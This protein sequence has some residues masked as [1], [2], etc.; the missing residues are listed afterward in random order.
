M[1]AVK[2][3][4]FNCDFEVL[5]LS[6][7]NNI[8]YFYSVREKYW[9]AN[10][11]V[12][13]LR[14]LLSHS[15]WY[16]NNLK[17]L[18]NDAHFYDFSGGA[19]GN[20]FRSFILIFERCFSEC[21]DFCKSLSNARNSFFFTPGSY[22]KTTESLLDIFDG[23]KPG[24]KY[25]NKILTENRENRNLMADAF[26][27]AEELIQECATIR[28]LGFYG[29]HQGFYYC[30]S[31]RRI[32]Q[33]VGVIVAT[34]SDLYQNTGGPIS[35]AALTILNGIKYIM[36]PELRAQQI[37]DV[38]QNSSVEFLKAFWSLSDIH[39][40]K[41]LP[42]WVCPKMEVKEEIFIPPEPVSLS[43]SDENGS[44]LIQAPSSHFP[45]APVRCLLLSSKRRE[46]QVVNCKKKIRQEKR[47]SC[48]L[49]H[50][51]GGGFIAQNPESHEIY[52]RHWA[53]DL[54]VPIL[55]VDYSLSPGAPFPRALE[56]VLFAYAWTLKNAEKLGWTGETL[57]CAGDSAGGN[58]LMGIILKII[59]LKIR[60]PDAVLCAY[61]PL[62][63]DMVPS[64][65]RLFC[66]IDPLLPLGFMISCLDAYAGNMQTDGDEYEE[67]PIYDSSAP[68][69][70]KISSI[71]EI[72]DSSMMFLKE[73]EWTEVEANEPFDNDFDF[74]YLNSS[75]D[76]N[77]NNP[78]SKCY[79]ANFIHSIT[80]KNKLRSDSESHRDAE[81][82]LFDFPNDIL[83]DIKSK[84]HVMANSSLKKL[85]QYF[86]S[87]HIY[88]KYLYP[89]VPVE[90]SPTQS[91]QS[92]SFTKSS[93]FSVLQKIKKLKIVSKNPF[94]S[95]LL[96][97]DEYLKQ[98][99]P[100]YFVSPNFDP[101]LDD[102]ITFAKRLASLNCRVVLDVLDGLPHG[103]LNFLPFSQEA[104]NGSNLC[105]RRLK[106]AMKIL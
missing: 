35:R 87:T 32:L 43:S 73:C 95:P 47:S 99:P 79:I 12:I 105:V 21:Y 83:F 41:K 23:L 36:N 58:I 57:C 81:Q 19:Q 13:L 82:S 5:Y 53:N 46:G 34:F 103:F 92:H 17:E 24:V 1:C 2:S 16:E 8:D 3:F 45:P 44:V 30:T 101:C 18:C 48:L 50:C 102:S 100:V 80:E 33:G 51:H 71:S 77:S 28:Q 29:R 25:L 6:L 31:M 72:F 10:K 84:C 59:S 22:I 106:E 74:Q 39:F 67:E 96:A 65:S 55:S 11:F 78:H 49:F 88:Q 54:N 60:S 76:R 69:S 104:H 97:P 27:T 37:V 14:E 15:H 4:D 91:N 63:L 9:Y 61:T 56:E 86:I 93:T 42:G 20:G 52:L 38:A 40:M 85:S 89:F 75:S 26:I 62:I 70:R 94:M 90:S 64:P 68:R 98:M 66:W 7:I